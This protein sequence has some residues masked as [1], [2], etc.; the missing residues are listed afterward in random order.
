MFYDWTLILI[1]PGLIFGLIAQ[2]RVKSAFNHASRVFS[3]RGYTADDIA[4][5]LLQRH[6]APNVAVTAT[7]GMLSDHYSPSQK[8]LALSE[9]V[10]GQSS[11]AAIGV[12]A[13]E[14]GHAIQDAEGY[15]FLR[16]RTAIVPVV[17][18]GS[19]LSPIIFMLGLILSMDPLVNVGIILFAL[20]VVFSLITLPVE[21]NASKRAKKL[22][23]AD[24]Y[25]D[26][27]EIKY[28]DKVL[29]AAALT[30]V[31]SLVSAVLQLL[32]LILI[33]NSRRRNN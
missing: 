15:S 29:D 16:F 31:A 28:V 12:A 20:T 17:S 23:L 10:Y 9:N 6:G 22:L 13:H 26:S 32:R 18:I 30:Y 24:G 21:F 8:T 14:A 19:N 2:A 7:K 25:L 5:R 27:Q 3:H 33:S 11:L 4:R 1:L